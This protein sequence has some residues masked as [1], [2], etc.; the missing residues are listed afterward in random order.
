MNMNNEHEHILLQD[1]K[2]IELDDDFVDVYQDEDIAYN[3]E[4][5]ENEI[6]IDD[7]YN[8]NHP[9]DSICEKSYRNLP[10]IWM[11]PIVEKLKEMLD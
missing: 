7:I 11:I 1:Y 5:D 2:I 10:E 9:W 6:D 8:D 4:F 3:D